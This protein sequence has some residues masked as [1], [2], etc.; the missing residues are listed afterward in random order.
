MVVTGGELLRHIE[1][2]TQRARVLIIEGEVV[3]VSIGA[4]AEHVHDQLPAVLGDDVITEVERQVALHAALG[5]GQGDDG[6][7]LVAALVLHLTLG[8]EEDDSVLLAPVRGVE[9]AVVDVVGGLLAVEVELLEYVAVPLVGGVQG[10]G[11]LAFAGA[12]GAVDGLLNQVDACLQLHDERRL[13]GNELAVAVVE[14][15][16]VVGGVVEL[17]ADLAGV[18]HAVVEGA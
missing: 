11:A 12:G 3:V 6:V 9:Y 4:V 17:E 7:A 8:V 2:V 18:V 14:R 10:H 15:P 1:E 13:G 16:V 5:P